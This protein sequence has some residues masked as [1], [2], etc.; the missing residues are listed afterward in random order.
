MK[1]C[2]LILARCQSGGFLD[3]FCCLHY[4]QEGGCKREGNLSEESEVPLLTA[5]KDRNLELSALN[6]GSDLDQKS[7]YLKLAYCEE[8]LLSYPDP[9]VP[10]AFRRRLMDQTCC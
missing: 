6:S 10:L 3:D 2:E 4:P 5:P 9:A 7:S 1:R 8:G